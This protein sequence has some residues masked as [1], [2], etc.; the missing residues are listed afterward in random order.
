MSAASV[1]NVSR[2]LEGWWSL[3]VVLSASS[4]HGDTSGTELSLMDRDNF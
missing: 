2:G 1:L 3:G 4:A